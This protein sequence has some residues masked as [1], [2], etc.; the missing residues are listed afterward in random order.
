MVVAAGTI[1]ITEV[2]A[3]VDG[4]D[5]GHFPAL[6]TTK[7]AARV[8][9]EEVAEAEAEEGWEFLEGPGATAQR[10]GAG[11]SFCPITVPP[12]PP[13]EAGGGRA[14]KGS[15]IHHAISSPNLR[16]YSFAS[17]DDG[18]GS[19][20]DGISS[21]VLV[22]EY[23]MS[24]AGS[25]A[26]VVSRPPPSAWSAGGLSFRDAILK[27]DGVD[28]MDGSAATALKLQR[29]AAAHH[30]HR[31][32]IVKKKATFV[33]VKP[34]K[35]CS[36]STG[37]LKALD[38]CLEDRADDGSGDVLGETD[39]QEYYGRKSAGAQGRRNGRKTRPDEARRL[40]WT[41]AKKELQRQ[42]QK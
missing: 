31:K 29:A 16:D 22:D 34:I 9:E 2:T 5:L 39:A 13:E 6:P 41:M 19:D 33:V 17:S 18:E 11:I 42:K 38:H 8:V 4:P 28:Q 32:R 1:S 35:R 27:S 26:V 24:D 23:A 21:A 7:A 40:Q 25:S 10:G 36:K 30:Q 37:D 14:E 20:S 3:G 15:V 12:T